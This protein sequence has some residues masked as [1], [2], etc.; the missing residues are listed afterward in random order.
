[1]IAGSLFALLGALVLATTPSDAPL[2][3]L[4]VA[5]TLLGFGQGMM[6][7]PLLVG[8]QTAVAYGKRGVATSLLNFSR[9]LGGAAGVAALGATLNAA[10]GPH[11]EELAALLDPRGQ[12]AAGTAAADERALLG[13]GLHTVF[14]GMAVLAVITSGLALRLPA[15]RFEELP[16]ETILEP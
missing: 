2:A 5:G 10:I 12:P 6:N 3:L 14:I 1:M 16:T 11:A 4:V 15:H 13:A 9:S 7:M 8:I